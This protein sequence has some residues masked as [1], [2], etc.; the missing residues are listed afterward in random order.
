MDQTCMYP[1]FFILGDGVSLTAQIS[2]KATPILFDRFTVLNFPTPMSAVTLLA[3]TDSLNNDVSAQV[4][5]NHSG[6]LVT[7]TFAT[8]FTDERAIRLRFQ[9]A[10]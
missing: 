4:S 10:V 1:V 8:P 7:I 2:L 5:I 9:F 3:A 6:T